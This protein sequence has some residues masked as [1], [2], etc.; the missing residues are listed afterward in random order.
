MLPTYNYDLY[1]DEGIVNAYEHY[2]KIR[3]LG[4]VVELTVTEALAVGRYE[5][6]RAILLDHTRFVSSKGVALNDATNKAA[7]GIPLTLDPPEHNRLRKILD[8]PLTR[9]AVATLRE[10]IESEADALIERLAVQGSF[11]G[12]KDLAQ[13]LPVSIVSS[14]VGL[15]EEGRDSMLAWAAASHDVNGPVNS[16]TQKGAETFYGMIEYVTN[17]VTPQNVRPDSWAAGIYKAAEKGRISHEEASRLIISYVVPSLETTIS[18]T[19]HMLDLFG[20]HSDQWR[21]LK[22]N[23][24]LIPNA[25]EEVLRIRTPVRSLARYAVE[26]VVI[27]GFEIPKGK[28]VVVLYASAN[29]DERKWQDPE[30]FDITRANARDHL[31]FGIG[32]HRCSGQ[33]LAKLEITSLLKAMVRRFDSFEIGDPVF[34]KNNILSYLSALP[35]Q[36]RT[37]S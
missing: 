16:R 37:R 17:K 30:R 4:P 22:E 36:L 27:D 28:F 11:D 33:Y 7:A 9:P 31:A 6:V 35:V 23:P 18:A 25:I 20:R 1:S 19:G 21:I 24:E 13:I 26:N 3:D 5:N 15:P 34:E 2:R 32:V 14:L 8:E 12:V 29:R 10:Q